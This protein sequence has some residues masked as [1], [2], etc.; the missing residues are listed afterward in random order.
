MGFIST[1]RIL[2]CSDL[3]LAQWG[4]DYSMKPNQ[5]TSS[6]VRKCGPQIDQY[7][8][9]REISILVGDGN[10]NPQSGPSRGATYRV[11][12]R[13]EFE[14]EGNQNPLSIEADGVRMKLDPASKKV[15]AKVNF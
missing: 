15:K 11:D 1:L 5:V 8:D 7:S 6:K 14:T 10:G 4:V 9:I 12:P 2:L 13:S 3:A